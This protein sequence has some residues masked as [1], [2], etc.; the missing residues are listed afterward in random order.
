MD[1]TKA[2]TDSGRLTISIK[3][4]RDSLLVVS[5][6]SWLCFWTF[7]GSFAF[8]MLVNRSDRDPFLFFWLCGWV[9]GESL[10]LVI[11]LWTAFGHEVIS[12]REGSFSHRREVFGLGLTRSYQVNEL[13]NL[14]A[15]GPFGD[16][17]FHGSLVWSGLAGGTVAVDTR[18]GD[19]YRFGN[20]L[21]ENDAFSLVKML[22]PYLQRNIQQAL[23]ADSPV[24]GLYS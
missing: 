5:V 17:G 9:V 15:S 8:S 11:L 1:R 23:G 14:R 4:K 7:G 2:S 22:E 3:A 21:E 12:I 18:Y 10:G 16:P 6:L 19:T 13:F 20:K 24:S